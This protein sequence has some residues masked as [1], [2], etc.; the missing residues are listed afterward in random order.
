MPVELLDEREHRL[1]R[2]ENV[3]PCRDEFLLAP[4][5]AQHV[6][7]AAHKGRAVDP[8]VFERELHEFDPRKHFDRIGRIALRRE[9]AQG[10]VEIETQED[11]PDV[12]E[13][14]GGLWNHCAKR[15]T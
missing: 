2:R 5:V 3:L 15:P 7:G 4:A 12:E 6:E 14:G 11:V 13:E 10:E 9:R 8:P 1:V